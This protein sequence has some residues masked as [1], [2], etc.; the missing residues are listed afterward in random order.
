MRFFPHR[1]YTAYRQTFPDYTLLPAPARYR[2][3]FFPRRVSSGA[4][5]AYAYAFYAVT[6]MKFFF[7]RLT[8][9]PSPAKSSLV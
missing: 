4:A 7:P 8:I 5:Q 3:G 1:I 6:F 2:M 9:I